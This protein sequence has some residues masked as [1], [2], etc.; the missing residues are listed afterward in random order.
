[1]SQISPNR[2]KILDTVTANQIAAG[3]VVERPSSVVK[4]LVENA[5]DAGSTKIEVKIKDAGTTLISVSDNGCGM[6]PDDL[7]KC[8][9]PHA[10]SKINKISDLDTLNTL[11]FRGEALAAISAVSKMTI[12]SK[13]EAQEYAY[14]IKSDGGKQQ[15]P[16]ETAAKNGTLIMVEDL[17]FNT[18]ARKKFLR[19]ASTETASISDFLSHLALS[20]P[21][22]AFQY[23]IDGRIALKTKGNGNIN[24]TVTAVYGQSLLENLLTVEGIQPFIINGLI[25]KPQFTKPNRNQYNF[26]VNGRWI[27]S[28][29]LSRCVDEVYHTIIPQGRYPF[30]LLFIQISPANI[31]VNIH[32]AKLEI[33]FKDSESVC[34]AVKSALQ[35]ALFTKKS[36]Q[37]VWQAPLNNS[38]NSR[39]ISC[40]RISALPLKIEKEI[41]PGEQK[42]FF[43]TESL[44]E[45]IKA[46]AKDIN[47][48]FSGKKQSRSNYS[49]EQISYLHNPAFTQQA[50][51]IKGAV[52]ENEQPEFERDFKYSDLQL[53]G[54]AAGTYII[55]AGKDGLYITDQHAAHERLLFEKFKKEADLHGNGSAPLLIPINIDFT[56]QETLLMSKYIVQLT[57]MGFIIEHFGDNTFVLRAVPLWYEGAAPDYLLQN[58]LAEFADGGKPDKNTVLEEKLFMAA[59][60][61]AIKANQYQDNAQI[62]SLFEELDKNPQL[63]TCPHGRPITVKISY[64][65]L[66]KRFYRSGI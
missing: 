12:I 55:A 46:G 60:K 43:K 29:E 33:K 14:S 38:V 56:H 50:N 20:H 54:Q 4:E 53:L 19:S 45:S 16:Q 58:L 3:E 2:I 27:Q 7:V 48:I 34:N 30:V 23:N 6:S 8:L 31:D 21:H 39:D 64:S 49:H 63:I 1:M 41:F 52:Q 65:E 66:Q 17:F 25:S 62:N 11:G 10:T 51:D 5:I 18:P 61:A 22:I 28:K 13:P 40:N 57:D 42:P 35:T 36:K 37:A 44:H 26:F 59:C 24:D 32:P 47:N 15:L 9:M